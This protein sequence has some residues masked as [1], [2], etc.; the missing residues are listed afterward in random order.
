MRPLNL[1]T[2]VLCASL[3]T[4]PTPIHAQVTHSITKIPRSTAL[5]ESIVKSHETHVVSDSTTSFESFS[6]SGHFGHFG[7]TV[8]SGPRTFVSGRSLQNGYGWTKTPRWRSRSGFSNE[9]AVTGARWNYYRLSGKVLVHID[10]LSLID[11]NPF[12]ANL[13]H[14]ISAM[15]PV[16]DR[17]RV[18]SSS[19][20]SANL[21]LD[22]SSP[23]HHGP[24][25]CPGSMAPSTSAVSGTSLAKLELPDLEFEESGLIS[26]S[27][28]VPPALPASLPLPLLQ[29]SQTPS[30]GLSP[31]VPLS[32][33]EPE[34]SP[35]VSIP[36][37]HPSNSLTLGSLPFA[38]FPSSTVPADEEFEL[39][40]YG[41]VPVAIPQL[42]FNQALG[43][44]AISL[45]VLS[46]ISTSQPTSQVPSIEEE[47]G[48][49]SLSSS[50]AAN[51]DSASL[52]SGTSLHHSASKSHSKAK[53]NSSSSHGSKSRSTGP[54][55]LL[56]ISAQAAAVV[57]A[58]S[59]SIGGSMHASTASRSSAP[60]SM[61]H[62]LSSAPIRSARLIQ[63]SAG[64]S[65]PPGE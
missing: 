16:P 9:T 8:Y 52:S 2:L 29:L 4:T 14:P 10:P 61:Y 6:G 18:R 49:V 7:F 51:P 21:E 22:H 47:S 35:V 58:L 23:T 40:S 55:T 62:V 34:P 63:T 50:F 19:S 56:S 43:T 13:S 46:P 38:S 24:L 33:E 17:L 3:S 48:A 60:L 26:V 20:H 31:F 44:L 41:V 15:A 54:H 39:P 5:T 12:F 57:L 25:F 30:S 11:R 32:L 65:L 59:S 37:V 42:S 36:L 45:S 53:S 27:L 1:R 28:C 64:I